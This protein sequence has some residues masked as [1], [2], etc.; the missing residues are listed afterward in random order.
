MNKVDTFRQLGKAISD[1]IWFETNSGAVLDQPAATEE[2]EDPPP[3]VEYREA[4]P[5]LQLSLTYACNMNCSYC[6]F[7]ERMEADGRPLN[8]NLDTALSTV[9]FFVEEIRGRTR[10]ARIDFGLTGETFLRH[11][12][13]N[14]LK[15]EIR[16][17]TNSIGL[18]S[19]GVGPNTTN[20][21][22]SEDIGF[23]IAMGPPQDISCDGPKEIH[24]AVRPYVDGRGTY[25]DLEPLIRKVLERHPDIGAT[26]VVTSRCTDVTR[27]FLHLHET[28]GFRSIYIKP[29]NLKPDDPDGL[30]AATVE[31]F[32]QGYT[33]FVEFV[34]AQDNPTKLRYLA[35]LSDEDFFMRYFYRVANRT[36]NTYRCGAGKSGAYVDTDG[37]LYPC[38]HFIGKTGYEIGNIRDGYDEARRQVFRDL[39]VEAR[40]PCRSCWAKYVCG[41]GCYYQAV[42]AN[43]RLDV[44]DQAKC[45]FV[46]HLVEL[47]VRL[48]SHLAETCHDILPALQVP[49]Q[50]DEAAINASA[51][52]E[53]RPVSRLWQEGADAERAV[54]LLAVPHLISSL[55]PEDGTSLKVMAEVQG[56]R[57]D[58]SFVAQGGAVLEEGNIW[59]IDL[60]ADPLQLRDMNAFSEDVFGRILHLR[61]D[62]PPTVSE[63]AMDGA[64]REVPYKQ[65]RRT[66][67]SQR[68]AKTR[69]DG[70]EVTI[71]FAELLGS[72]AAN[73]GMNVTC[74]MSDGRVAKLL[75]AEPFAIVD[76]SKNGPLGLDTPVWQAPEERAEINASAF[77]GL[78]P[79]HHWRGLQQNVC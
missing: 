9:D 14:R 69:N 5:Q 10:H 71:D 32:R 54:E 55:P 65:R 56:G 20:G 44:P 79:L 43:G 62:E 33:D 18:R 61:R 46:T 41:G 51:D 22:L 35:S 48:Y 59:M 17:R 31:Q 23:E 38:A 2:I 19:V 74:R 1:R 64:F 49:I 12:V 63:P 45:D 21:S 16:E 70:W 50:I 68:A 78:M 25:E 13:H 8:M 24:D 28:L 34:I 40:E 47:A 75:R 72:A 77:S 36:R 73:V 39:T 67:V 30:N 42:L 15:Q 27:I 53:Y 52:A 7:R 6:S 3:V 57:L 66:L 76:L 4:F 58:I 26:A 60:D 11:K 37:N 29:V